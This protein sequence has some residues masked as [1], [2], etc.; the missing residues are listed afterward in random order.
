MGVQGGK[1]PGSFRIFTKLCFNYGILGA[2]Y[3][4]KS[5]LLGGPKH[6]VA[7]PTKILGGPRP[8]PRTPRFLRLCGGLYFLVEIELKMSKTPPFTYLKGA[9]SGIGAKTAVEFARKGASVALTGRNA[10]RLRK[11]ADECLSI[12]LQSEK[13]N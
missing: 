1:A 7:P 12:G 4:D 10:E 13:V 8:P 6:I 11:T 2:I 5:E 3:Q 9:S